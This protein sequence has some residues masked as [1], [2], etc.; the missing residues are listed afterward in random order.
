MVTPIL[1]QPP[2][3]VSWLVETL[4]DTTRYVFKREWLSGLVTGLLILTCTG[5]AVCHRNNAIEGCQDLC[6][7]GTTAV[8]VHSQGCHCATEPLFKP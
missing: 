3:W 6:P 7:E 4:D 1:P 8:L 2:K 5:L